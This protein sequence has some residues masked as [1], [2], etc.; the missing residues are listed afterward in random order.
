VKIDVRTQFDELYSAHRANLIRAAYTR[1]RLRQPEAAEDIVDEVFMRLWAQMLDGNVPEDPIEY[2]TYKIH[3]ET[4][5]ERRRVTRR[6]GR[7]IPAGLE[8]HG[9]DDRPEAHEDEILVSPQGVFQPVSVAPDNDDH[10][11]QQAFDLALRDLDADIRDAFILTELRGL[12]VRDAA[13]V[14]GVS[15]TTVARRFEIARIL[16]QKELT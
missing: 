2:L 6:W 4:R 10:E 16:I 12:T 5:S 15:H 7:E 3:T 8:V 14:L 9:L 1:L 13:G 11:F